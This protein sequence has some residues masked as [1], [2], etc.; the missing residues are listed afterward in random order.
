MQRASFIDSHGIVTDVTT[1]IRN[2]CLNRYVCRVNL[3]TIL[4]GGFSIPY[5]FEIEYSTTK[6]PNKLK[7]KQNKRYEHVTI[8]G[9]SSHIGTVGRNTGKVAITLVGIALAILAL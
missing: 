1:Q 5:S 9:K 3:A 7:V 4:G 2:Y 8:K 6:N